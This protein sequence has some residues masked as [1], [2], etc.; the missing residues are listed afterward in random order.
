[1][2]FFQTAKSTFMS[3]NDRQLQK[4]SMTGSRGWF[5]PGRN[6]IE[7]ESVGL[8][9]SE[10]AANADQIVAGGSMSILRRKGKK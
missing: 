6:D 2:S 9:E 3:S 8:D 1:M 10:L 4:S 5:K 7:R